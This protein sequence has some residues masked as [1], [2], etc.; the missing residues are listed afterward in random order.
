VATIACHAEPPSLAGIGHYTSTELQGTTDP[1][2]AEQ[3]KTNAETAM[4]AAVE[5]NGLDVNQFNQIVLA[6]ATDETIRS[7]VDDGRN[8]SR[9]ATVRR[10]STRS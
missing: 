4:I 3:A 9:G 7:R 1:A 6:M 5:R 10:A 8:S 2:K